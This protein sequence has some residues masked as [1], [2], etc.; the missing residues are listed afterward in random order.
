MLTDVRQSHELADCWLLSSIAGAVNA[1][2]NVARQLVA[3]LGDGTYVVQL[4]NKQYRV[5][6]DLAYLNGDTGNLKYADF[7]HDDSLWVAIVE[8]AW[9]LHRDGT[10][11]SLNNDI[12]WG[13]LGKIG[14]NY[15]T[16]ASVTSQ[17]ASIELMA[18]D[19]LNQ[20]AV[21]PSRL[22]DGSTEVLTD[23]HCYAIVGVGY[24]ADGFPATVT[25][26]NPYGEDG[27]VNYVDDDPYDGFVT[28]TVA[29]WIRDA[30][31]P[32]GLITANFSQYA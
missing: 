30:Q 4:N 17:T 10:Y 3:D 25:L 29:Q 5:D 11:D 26:Y 27:G 7:G 19:F 20:A 22:G 16:F 2:A 8:K 1:N 23:S 21:A 15:R 24:G 6:G 13:A 28:I 18:I 14:G 12:P 32:Y 9:A 31:R